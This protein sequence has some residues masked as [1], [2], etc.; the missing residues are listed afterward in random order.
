[1]NRKLSSSFQALAVDDEPQNLLI[2][3][4]LS[5]KLNIEIHS[6]LNPH[7]A[8]NYSDM[9]EIDIAFVDYMLPGT[10][11]IEVIKKIRARHS[12]I[13]IVMIT[14]IDNKQD[15]R[16]NA[17][18]TGATEFLTK[19]INIHEFIARVKNL[20]ELRRAQ[21]LLKDKAKLLEDEVEKTTSHII[22]REYETLLVIGRA[23]EYRD[24]ETGKHIERVAHYSRIIS[25]GLGMDKEFQE[26]IYRSAPLHDIGKIGI[27]DN[28]LFKEDKLTE[29]EF[30]IIKTHAVI[31]NK[32]LENTHSKYLR[33]G[34]TIALSHHERFDGEGYPNRQ[35]G[36]E[37]H[38]YGRIVALADVFDALTNKRPY[39]EPWSIDKVFDLLIEEKRRH[40]DPEIIEVF[41]SNK[42]KV[43]SIFNN[44]RDI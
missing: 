27:S 22:Q 13:P 29:K 30:E 6:Y 20:L 36:E 3:E 26:I 15:V 39:K 24:Q 17:I 40:F 5:E 35:A 44:F 38:I 21:L 14:A 12:E 23:A 33:A 8:L 43:L 37:I 16:Y 41:M 42:K 25:Q 1:M 7:E 10:D 34:A 2:L 18:N 32:I 31:G 19:P 9:H 4:K 11:G 28:L